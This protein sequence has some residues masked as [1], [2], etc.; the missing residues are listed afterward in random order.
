MTTDATRTA[1]TAVFEALIIPHRSLSGRGLRWLMAAFA[2]CGVLIA[3][4][5][6][7]LGAWPVMLFAGVE[8]AAAAVLLWLNARR[9]RASELVILDQTS[10]R[11]IRTDAGGRRQTAELPSAW[12]TV[13]LVD[14]PGTAPR[15]LVGNRRN[16]EEV[17]TS[18]NEAERRDLAEALRGA[19]YRARN[20]SFDNPQLQE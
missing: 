8:I 6:W 1:D 16:W 12:L 18:L 2:G 13:R 11:V 9:A 5:F 17:G 10:L 4:R 14:Q 15:L 20:P 7:L 3:F 19:L